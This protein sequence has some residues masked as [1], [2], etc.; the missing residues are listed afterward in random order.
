M[1]DVVQSGGCGCCGTAVADSVS[2]VEADESAPRTRFVAGARQLSIDGNDLA[3]LMVLFDAGDCAAVQQRMAQI[4]NALLAAAELRVVEQIEQAARIQSEAGGHL[5]GL[6]PVAADLQTE[7]TEP[8]ALVARLQGAAHRLAQ[9]PA[10]G[11]ACGADCPCV[12]AA[13]AVTAVRIPAARAALTGGATDGAADGPDLVCTIDGGIDA[14]YGRINEW[15][16]VI[17]RATGREP[18][19]GGVTL[20]FEHHPAMTVELARLVAA[21][22]ACCSF[23]TFT[24]TVG[25]AGMRFRVTAPPEA[26]DVVTAV[27]GTAT[28]AGA[29]S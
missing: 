15:Q 6:S 8:A 21:E 20:T 24:L 7:A 23:F 16:A 2:Q 26:S 12:T 22:Y 1:S 11:A 14:M 18:A 9:P 29:R 13:S 27:F 4:V 10:G 19:D 3:D 25:P 5:P 28:P 17:E